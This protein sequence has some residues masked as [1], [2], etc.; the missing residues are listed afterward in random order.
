MQAVDTD[1][2]AGLRVCCEWDEG[3]QVDYVS[4]CNARVR[5]TRFSGA[6]KSEEGEVVWVPGEGY[7]ISSG[8]GG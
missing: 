5:L 3:V 6:E 2:M 7:A 1:E 4:A 8:W